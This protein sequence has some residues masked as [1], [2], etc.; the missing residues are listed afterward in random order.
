LTASLTEQGKRRTESTRFRSGALAA[1]RPL[2]PRPGSRPTR[3][4]RGAPAGPDT[5]WPPTRRDGADLVGG[6]AHLLHI[7]PEQAQLTLGIGGRDRL[8]RQQPRL[9]AGINAV[10][11]FPG[12]GKGPDRPQSDDGVRRGLGRRAG[13]RGLARRDRDRSRLLPGGRRPGPR[14]GRPCRAG[15]AIPAGRLARPPGKLC[16]RSTWSSQPTGC[17]AGSATWTAGPP[18]AH[19]PRSPRSAFGYN[20]GCL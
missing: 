9:V 13:R 11:E 17:C 2:G 1:T 14:A 10:L 15:R 7:G 16:D 6:R 8:G 5:G 4:C 19:Q 3:R 18:R 20:S 12:L